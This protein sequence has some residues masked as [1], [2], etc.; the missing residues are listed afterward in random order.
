[1]GLFDGLQI[2]FF[3]PKSVGYEVYLVDAQVGS[4]IKLMC[5][6]YAACVADCVGALS[7]ERRCCVGDA[8][9]VSGFW[10]CRETLLCGRPYR[11]VP[12]NARWRLSVPSHRTVFAEALVPR[13]VIHKY[14]VS[15][16]TIAV[17][18]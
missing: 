18:R 7:V 13:R 2:R 9:V 16:G 12:Y 14:A 17:R 8:G 1:M 3:F 11:C 4:F 5:T 10:H 15:V 6:P